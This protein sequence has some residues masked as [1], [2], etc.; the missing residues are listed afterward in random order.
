MI[1]KKPYSLPQL[2]RVQ[3]DQEQAILS[4]CSLATNSASQG[5]NGGCRPNNFGGCKRRN[6]GGQTDAGPRLS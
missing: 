5:G 3:L 2:F 1:K 4:A 6:G